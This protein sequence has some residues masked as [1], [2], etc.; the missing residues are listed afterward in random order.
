MPLTTQ[1][2]AKS[3]VRLYLIELSTASLRSPLPSRDCRLRKHLDMEAT[4]QA[5][6]HIHE[7]PSLA[8]PR[9]LPCIPYQ[10]KALGSLSQAL[11]H[12]AKS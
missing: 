7:P 10:L 12:E 4:V 9:C 11:L 2:I 1:H 8:L 3:G 6:S 5:H